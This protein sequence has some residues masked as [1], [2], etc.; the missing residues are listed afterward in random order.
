M[1]KIH[2]CNYYN[3]TYIKFLELHIYI[4]G[5]FPKTS[6]CWLNSRNLLGF[7]GLFPELYPSFSKN[8]CKISLTMQ[9][10]KDYF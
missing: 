2:Q 8:V 7:L 6:Y 5:N 3:I 1:A 10:Y 4:E 9:R